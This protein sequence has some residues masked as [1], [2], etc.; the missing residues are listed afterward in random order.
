MSEM[1]TWALPKE[2]AARLLICNNATVGRVFCLIAAGYVVRDISEGD[3]ANYIFL[4]CTDC[5]ALVSYSTKLL[6]ENTYLRGTPYTP[7]T[8]RSCRAKRRNTSTALKKGKSL[9]QGF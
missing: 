1:V 8:C 6:Y 7:P 2:V 5:K 3:E 4:D 9:P